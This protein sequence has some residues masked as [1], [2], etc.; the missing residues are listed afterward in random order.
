MTEPMMACVDMPERDEESD[1]V[2]VVVEK[3]LFLIAA[4]GEVIHPV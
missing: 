2:L 3:V 1:A 4:G